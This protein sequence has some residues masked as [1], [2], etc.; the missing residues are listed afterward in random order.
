MLDPRFM[1]PKTDIRRHEPTNP[2]P[3]T[4][5]V[6]PTRTAART[7]NA[8]PSATKS[9]AESFPLK[10]PNFRIDTELPSC[11]Q[12]T[13]ENAPPDRIFPMTLKPDPSFTTALMLSDEPT[14]KKSKVDKA[15]ALL[16]KLRTLT[17]LPSAT[18]CTTLK[19]FPTLA[20]DRTLTLEP[21][22]MYWSALIPPPNRPKFR[23]DNELANCV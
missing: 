13:M 21:T 5:Q 9:K 3:F 12:S 14:E 11:K 18:N 16:V 1:H 7:D 19:D 17:L 4:L 10:R 8:E 15:P 2:Q 6:E 22:Y 23:T 20:N